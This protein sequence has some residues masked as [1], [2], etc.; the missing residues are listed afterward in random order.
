MLLILNRMKTHRIC[1]A[2]P[3][4]PCLRNRYQIVRLEETISTVFENLLCFMWFFQTLLW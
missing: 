1:E 4:Y 3:R 2:W